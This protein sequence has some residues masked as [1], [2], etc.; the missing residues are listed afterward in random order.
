M[1]SVYEEDSRVYELGRVD[2]GSISI[3]DQFD[4]MDMKYYPT[5]WI[6]K[7]CSNNSPLSLMPYTG[8]DW[9]DIISV[10]L[11]DSNGKFEVGNCMTREELRLCIEMEGHSDTPSY[12]QCIYSTPRDKS[13][14]NLLTG[15]TGIPTNRL[16]FKFPSNGMFIT[17]GSLKRV[18]TCTKIRTWY[19][20]P[21]FGGKR[22]R[23]GNIMGQYG[24]SMNHGQVPGYQVYK[25]YTK[26]EIRSGVEAV[27]AYDDY[28]IILEQE[29]II[30]RG[31]GDMDARK[32]VRKLVD[33]I[34]PPDVSEVLRKY[35][36]EYME[37]NNFIYKMSG[38]SID[39]VKREDGSFDL[40]GVYS[41][42][43]EWF[44][45]DTIN[46]SNR[47]ITSIPVYPNLKKL[48]CTFNKITSVPGYPMLKKLFCYNS[49]VEEIGGCPALRVLECQNNKLKRLDKSFRRLEKLVCS[50]NGLEELPSSFPY[51]RLL[52]CEYNK[53]EAIPELEVLELLTCSH[54]GLRSLG[55]YPKLTLLDCS[56]N[57][58]V[59]L[60][61]MN[62]LVSLEC[63]NNK[64]ETFPLPPFPKLRRLDCRKNPLESIPTFQNL[65]CVTY[66]KAEVPSPHLESLPDCYERL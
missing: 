19:A 53:L 18:M 58:I 11:M 1:P 56:N 2:S 10:K 39:S 36:V 42:Y 23:V 38:V 40:V 33:A 12:I 45:V 25:L 13:G 63:Q 9:D 61:A 47:G 55:S 28:I 44:Y 54:N 31:S 66:D 8:E 4:D 51:L 43:M 65:E 59:S 50:F 62:S 49:E 41:L 26:S 46:C 35:K 32:F 37:P 14:S 22:R 15:M 60:G 24:M 27:E 16:L 7:C 6:E 57:Q 34:I 20:L 48:I 29:M 5:D 52:F 17:I 21:L 3:F 64:L 30:T